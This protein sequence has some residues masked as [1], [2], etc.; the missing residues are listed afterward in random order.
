ML[1]CLRVT[2]SQG[3][4]DVMKLVSRDTCRAM[5]RDAA[6]HALPEELRRRMRDLHFLQVSDISTPL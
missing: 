3:E 4:C 2:S 5:S 1:W 6:H